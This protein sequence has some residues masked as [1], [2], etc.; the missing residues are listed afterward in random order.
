MCAVV[1]GQVPDAYATTAVAAD[2]LALVGMNDNIVDG[3]A[4][5]VAALNGGRSRVPNLDGTVL[6]A[7]NHPLAFAMKRNTRNVVGV[8]LKYEKRIGVCRLNVKELDGVVAGDGE[9]ALIGRYAET[10]DLRIGVLNGTGA[11]ARKGFPESNGVVIASYRRCA[12][13]NMAE[14]V[15]VIAIVCFETCLY[16]K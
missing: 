8:A 15:I 9:E 2:N 7:R 12:V 13:S 14:R 1:F 10:I 6:G 11:Y 4:V 5:V 3:G 16:T